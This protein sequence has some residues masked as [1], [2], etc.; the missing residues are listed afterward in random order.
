[1]KITNKKISTCIIIAIGT[2]LFLTGLLL[3]VPGTQLTT[4]ENLDGQRS[5]Y[6]QGRYSSI[7]EYVGGDAYNFIIGA[8][9]IG[10][11]IAGVKTEK[12]VF[13][14]AGLMIISLGVLSYAYFPDKQKP[15][16]TTDNLY[17]D[18]M[19]NGNYYS[20][21]NEQGVAQNQ[22]YES[23]ESVP[24]EMIQSQENSI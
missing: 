2:I 10:G 11:K 5:E 15:R 14:S 23:T 8:S 12:A 13:I 22:F 3:R 19:E 1:M 17:A 18:Y 16:P 21:G 20:S 24:S 9:L 6:H 7:E 4:Y